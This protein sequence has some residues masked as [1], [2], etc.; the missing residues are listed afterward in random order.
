MHLK[1]AAEP[2]QGFSPSRY[3]LACCNLVVFPWA[4]SK[5]FHTRALSVALTAERPKADKKSVTLQ[6][7][8]RVP[9]KVCQAI[10]ARTSLKPSLFRTLAS[11]WPPTPRG[12][13]SSPEHN[14]GKLP[15]PDRSYS[16]MTQTQCI[17]NLIFNVHYMTLQTQYQLKLLGSFNQ[18]SG[19][20][21]RQPDA[22]TAALDG[23]GK[24]N[25]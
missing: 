5:R 12:C 25:S 13:Q 19:V 21:R 3:K 23:I 14:E 22:K 20:L 15:C 17:R 4:A 2:T 9:G 24:R 10:L 6:T 1:A 16:I 18:E 11:I 7:V 8:C